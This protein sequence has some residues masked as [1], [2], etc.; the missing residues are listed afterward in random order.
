MEESESTE[1]SSTANMRFRDRTDAG[2]RLAAAL[3]PLAGEG[4][5]VLALPRGGVAVGYEIA[6][7]L[8]APLDVWVVRKVGV[9]WQPELGVGA[10]AES[11]P[12]GGGG[13][14][15][16][17]RDIQAEVRLSEEEL[18][19]A[20]EAE[21]EEVAERVHR[22]RGNRPA[23]DLRGRTVIVVDDGIATGGTVRAAL[24]TVR[25]AGPRHVILAV[26][27]APPSTL[28]ALGPEADAVVCLSTPEDLRAIGLWYDNFEQVSDSEV[29]R[30]LSRAREEAARRAAAGDRSGEHPAASPR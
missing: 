2:R 17:S 13:Y 25:A 6:R 19:A 16:V 14:V 7:A 26:P 5:I 30:L 3:E 8:A 12:G 20:V 23:P 21:R 28:D 1:P 11:G 24:R 22:F 29:V 15:H 4:A 27:V 10:I 18:Q 9:P